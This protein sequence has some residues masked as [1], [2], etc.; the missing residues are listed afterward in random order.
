MR[1][2]EFNPDDA[3]GKAMELF[4]RKGYKRTSMRDL[5]AHT[6]VSHEGLYG[7]FGNKKQLFQA[8]L[9]RYT[10]LVG[11]ETSKSL[12]RPDTSL[13]D[14]KAFFAELMKKATDPRFRNG[15]LACN[16]AFEM[17]DEMPCAG[18]AMRHR[19]D[20]M[21]ELFQAALERARE[22]GEIADDRD[23]AVLAEF[24]SGTMNAMALMLRARQSH[25]KIECFVKTALSVLE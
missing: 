5:V 18:V 8:V 16:A 23:P 3:L 9:G 13:P 19:F 1:R 21:S 14:I 11:E 20:H 6:G 17:A 24:L 7:A 12:E 2:R 4:W 22:R 15:C 25:A 10:Q